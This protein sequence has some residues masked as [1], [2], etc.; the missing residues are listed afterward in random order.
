MPLAGDWGRFGT[1]LLRLSRARASRAVARTGEQIAGDIAAR[2][3]DKIGEYQGAVAPFPAWETLAESTLARK[4]A[5]TPLYESGDLQQAITTWPG[6]GPHE[7]MVG[8]VPGDPSEAAGKAA[9]LGTAHEPQRAFLGPAVVE[10]GQNIT[11]YARGMVEA[12][13]KGG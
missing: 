9:E 8:V 12:V 5:D 13:I 11:G 10:A 6:R 7:W 3:K 2:A 1:A 4:A